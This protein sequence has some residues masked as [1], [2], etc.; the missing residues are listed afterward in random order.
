MKVANLSSFLILPVLNFASTPNLNFEP[1]ATKRKYPEAEMNFKKMRNENKSF[2]W[3]LILSEDSSVL[4][5]RSCFKF[6]VLWENVS[7]GL[8]EE[9][10]I[11][12]LLI[13]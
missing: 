2:Y 7:S 6:V 12:S 3:A 13:W 10:K 11:Y 9:E 8:N 1:A 5:S 4:A